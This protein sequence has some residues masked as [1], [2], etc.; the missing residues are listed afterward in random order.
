M[1]EEEFFQLL[2]QCSEELRHKQAIVE[3]QYGLRHLNRWH[4][5]QNQQALLFLNTEG[6]VSTQFPVT[7]IGTYS[8]SKE[9]WKWAWANP[10]IAKPL[11]EKAAPLKALYEKTDFELFTD[12]EEFSVDEGMAWELAAISVQHLNA[13]GCYRA[14][15]KE[16]FLFLALEKPL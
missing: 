9:T 5:D 14:P 2:E 12:K 15:N 6:K 8:S 13:I 11:Q 7:P 1:N 4:L 10:F 3:A 16:T